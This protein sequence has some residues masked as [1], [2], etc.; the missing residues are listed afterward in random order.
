VN[1]S[2][3][4]AL[5]CAQD[6]ANQPELVIGSIAAKQ[7][8]LALAAAINSSAC[9]RNANLKGRETFCLSS[10]DALAPDVIDDWADRARLV[11]VNQVEG[12]RRA[13]HRR[14]VA[15]VRLREG[16]DVNCMYI[17]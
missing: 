5:D 16:A 14:P 7:H 6:L 11:G 1:E 13:A 3:K 17:S 12:G 2:L 9:F 10:E 4:A 8:L 15:R